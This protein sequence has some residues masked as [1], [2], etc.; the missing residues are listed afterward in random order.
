M[1]KKQDEFE[2]IKPIKPIPG[3]MCYDEFL[4]PESEEE[5]EEN[6]TSVAAGQMDLWNMPPQPKI[7]EKTIVKKDEKS[8]IQPNE[9]RLE[10][11]E[12]LEEKFVPKTDE[13]TQEKTDFE[14]EEK[15][16]IFE[17]KSQE[18]LQE[19]D[20]KHDEK[21]DVV[22]VCEIP[23][24]VAQDD[25]LGSEIVTENVDDVEEENLAFQAPKKMRKISTSYNIFEEENAQEFEENSLA[26]DEK[27][28]TEEEQG[29]EEESD[30]EE[31]EKLTIDFENPPKKLK[32]SEIIATK[33]QF[34][35]NY[36]NPFDE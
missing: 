3:Q 16:E 19:I 15:S 36:E 7:D 22:E 35:G 18:K 21:N 33:T 6:D 12:K 17:E 2:E 8:E 23:S 28:E 9:K 1:E 24:V 26:E 11:E 5:K 20:E 32:K 4:F 29:F 14:V 25:K 27:N 34:F 31:D 10:N 30:L 13:Q